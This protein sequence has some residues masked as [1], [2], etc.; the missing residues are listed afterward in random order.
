MEPFKQPVNPSPSAPPKPMG[1]MKARPVAVEETALSYLRLR[2][3][4]TDGRMRVVAAQT[5]DG[6]LAL[7]TSFV[8]QHAYEIMLDAHPIAVEGLPDIGVSRSYPRPG[9]HEHHITS[10][11]TFEFTVR[12]PRTALPGDALARLR[13]TLYR[14][15]DASPKTVAGPLTRQ[16]GQQA[17]VVALMDGVHADHIEPQALEQLKRL[18]PS[19]FAAPR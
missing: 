19:S 12:I 1:D 6:P 15:P 2:I 8:G 16:F 10:R 13:V 4:V 14:F 3:R 7:S 5:V 9:E 11:P 17:T 18:F